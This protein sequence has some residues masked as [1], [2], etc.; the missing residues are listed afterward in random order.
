MAL[1]LTKNSNSN[2]LLKGRVPTKNYINLAKA[3]EKK[4]NWKIAIPVI[5]LILAAA[6]LFSK[7]L[8][9]DRFAKVAQAEA[10]VASLQRQID[11]MYAEIAGY[12]ELAE[13]YAHYTYANMTEEELNR[14]D[15]ILIIDMLRNKVMDNLAVS[16]WKVEKDQ[17]VVT[18]T[19]E[20][21]EKIDLVFRNLLENESIV[22]YYM[23]NSAATETLIYEDNG[24]V[25]ATVTVKIVKPAE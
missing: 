15:R 25:T 22:D 8:V 18:V 16:S 13:L 5:V 6:V 14:V 21:L 1:T 10:E 7:F 20:S 23:V 11:D 9:I 4:I 17:L 24:Y 2:N 3:D 12:G 19:G